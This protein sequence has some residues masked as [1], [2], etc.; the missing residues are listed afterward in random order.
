M[1]K[2]SDILKSASVKNFIAAQDEWEKKCIEEAKQPNT[3]LVYLDADQMNAL[4]KQGY[5]KLEGREEPIVNEAF[6][7]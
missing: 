4:M 7:K 5:V 6:W 3:E 2:I 1:S